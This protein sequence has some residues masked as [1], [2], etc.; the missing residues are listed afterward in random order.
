MG[1]YVVVEPNDSKL[2]EVSVETPIQSV[3]DAAVCK[4][5]FPSRR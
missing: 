2:Y 1:R 5:I 4:D 3:E